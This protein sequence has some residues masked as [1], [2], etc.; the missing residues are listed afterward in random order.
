MTLS[1]LATGFV[2]SG[3][4]SVASANA[5]LLR[6][7]LMRNYRVDF[8][9]KPSFVDP[10]PTVADLPQCENLRLVDCTNTNADSLRRWLS[11]QGR[12]VW[13][14][15]WG[16]VDAASYNRGLVRRMRRQGGGDLDFWFGDW[17]RGRGRRPVVSLVQGPPGSDA[18][19]LDRHAELI[20]RLAGK[21]AWYQ[22]V[23][24]ARYRLSIGLPPFQ[25]TDQVIV[26]SEWSRQQLIQR[27][28]FDSCRTHA[29][30]Y[31]IDLQA[32]YPATERR[33]SQ[34][35]LRVLW[36]GR[37]VPRKR[38]DLF[39]DGL[40]LAI[41]EGCDVEAW[42][43]GQSGFVP[44]Y[45]R[46]L[47]EF[48]YPERLQHWPSVPRDKVPSMIAD[49]DVMA[50]PSDDEDFGSSV[51]EALSC[52]V[53][54]IVGASNGTGDYLCGR[55]IRLVDDRPETFAEAIMQMAK[56]KRTGDLADPNPSRQ[57]AERW[58]APERVVDRL[59]AILQQCN[60]LSTSAP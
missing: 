56:A 21:A 45:E 5:V 52:G 17:A 37:F 51:A 12:G 53:P 25:H 32:F 58:F 46:L 49:V 1:I 9:T 55:S 36:L 26:G 35:R 60:R 31:P 10:R 38:L 43:V 59:E 7:L 44:N 39:L 6:H 57:T 19:S 20:Q 18:R 34:A 28:K 4:G 30:P 42:V 3:S 15:L 22:L 47:H 40:A 2:A 11:P 16:Q 24:Y 41:K 23:A 8:F 48:S 14:Q 27:Y 50:Q 33:P 13:G 54:A 29:L